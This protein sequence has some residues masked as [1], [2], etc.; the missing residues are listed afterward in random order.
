MHILAPLRVANNVSLGLDYINAKT[1]C[2][3]AIWF[4]LPAPPL[5][6]PHFV[7]VGLLR[8]DLVEFI[9]RTTPRA[10]EEEP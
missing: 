8:E 6:S 9:Q 5:G 2:G 3:E 1:S 4:S 10:G 7:E